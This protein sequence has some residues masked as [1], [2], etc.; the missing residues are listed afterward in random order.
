MKK[1]NNFKRFIAGLVS[2]AM[3]MASFVFPVTNAKA[4]DTINTSTGVSLTIH[5]YEYTSPGGVETSG[6]GSASDSVPVGATGLNGVEFTVYKIADIEQGVVDGK[7][8]IRYKTLSDLVTAG[9][10]DYIDGGMSETAIK[11]AF[12]DNASVNTALN[13]R[14]DGTNKVKKE[15]E[16]V[17]GK[18]GIAEFTNSDLDG[19]GL[20]LVVET[21]KPAKVTQ[22]MAPFLVSLPTTLDNAGDSEWLYNVHA[23]PKNSTKTS[24]I[25]I[26]KQEKVADLTDP[27]AIANASFYLQMKVGSTWVTQT[28]NANNVAIGVDGLITLTNVAGYEVSDLA[29]GEYRF[30]EASAP[31]DTIIESDISHTFTIDTDGVVWIGGVENATLTVV[32]DKPSITK[33]VLKKG[34][35]IAVDKDWVDYADY[36]T[37]EDVT[38]KVSVSIPDSIKKLSTYYIVDKFDSGLFTIIPS[39]FSYVF[40]TGAGVT[41]TPTGAMTSLTNTPAVDPTGWTLELIDDKTEL[42]DNNITAIDIIFKGTLSNTAVTAGNGNVNTAT[43]EF[44]NQVFANPATDPDNPVD[45]DPTVSEETTTIMDKAAVYT[46]ELNLNKTFQGNPGGKEAKFDLYKYDT[47]SGTTIKV[48]GSDVKVTKININAFEVTEGTTFVW[49]TSASGEADLGLSNGTYYL[50]ET[51]TDEGYNLLKEPVEVNILKYY[52]KTF[53]TITTVTKYDAG[54]NIIGTPVTTTTG[55][56][57]S[58][59]YS[60]SEKT[61]E[62]TGDAVKTIV[63]IENK[64]G[65]VFPTTGGRGTIIFTITGLTLMIVAVCIF[66]TSRKRKTN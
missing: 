5:K 27:V 32:N 9:A 39:S 42:S 41:K 66:F 47:T 10:S 61:A 59:F 22:A 64:K 25:T 46:F 6:T 8:V 56:E 44:T 57:S 12:M 2:S 35:D 23:F 33:K 28:K 51:D 50:V 49:N 29:P 58:K 19:Q 45:P 17:G 20:Y 15:T 26:K 52:T 16:T 4:D 18:D 14:A 7:N 21:K 24:A 48:N 40:Y 62:I 3:V 1:K 65:F 11:T 13:A 31:D 30:V 37:G 36:S 53:E 54:G 34:G 63:N 43:L 38:Y 60:N 55:T